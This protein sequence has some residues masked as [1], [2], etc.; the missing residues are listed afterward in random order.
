MPWRSRWMTLNN[1][2]EKSG[3][4]FSSV[5]NE[6]LPSHRMKIR[7]QHVSRIEDGGNRRGAGRFATH[8]VLAGLLLLTALTSSPL[9]AQTNTAQGASP[10]QRWL[11]I[12]ETSR[13]MQR[14]S[15][16]VFQTVQDLLTSGMAGQLRSGDTLGVWTFGDDLYAGRFALQIWSPE[17]Q[18]NIA[19]STLTFLKGQKYGKQA[20]F[21]KVLPALNQVIKDSRLL[22]VVLVSSGDQKMRGTLFDAQINEFWQKWHTPQQ[23]AR[24]P[25][26]TVLRA[27]AGQLTEYALNTP[28]WPTQMPRLSQETQSAEAIPQKP[29]EAP[30]NPAPRAVPPLIISGKKPQAEKAPP[31]KP[32]PTVVKTSVPALVAAAPSTNNLRAANPPAP[33]VPPVQTTKTEAA[34]ITPA[35]PW[36]E[37][38]PNPLPTPVLAAPPK[39]EAVKAPESKPAEPA[40]TKPEVAATVQ[41]L[42]AKPKPVVIELP[43]PAPALEP[44]PAPALAA[45]LAAPATQEVSASTLRPRPSTPAPSP[46]AIA[47][48]PA[49]TVAAVPA[50]TVAGH[51]SIWI[52]AL[53][54]A[55]IA[56][57]FAVLLL[58]RSRATPQAS[59]ITRS[60]EQIRTAAGRD[61]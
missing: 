25:F 30:H 46:S 39:T 53:V 5:S 1:T 26:V 19:S 57:G 29:L 60:F 42:P 59:L 37:V 23:K 54:F 4:A 43:K 31:P 13:S 6:T 14:R 34:P 61:T 38:A 32:E 10:A 28:P 33:V 36:A 22:T 12:V 3:T 17:A 49:Q 35:K 24:M 9:S 58:R 7:Y 52:A 47:S 11:L 40:P 8:P 21:D 27:K 15:E 55:G 45:V 16:A 20:N 2:T 18:Q 41:T 51:K 48:P 56:A 50:E 44:K